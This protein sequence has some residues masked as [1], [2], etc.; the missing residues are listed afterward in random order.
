M[1]TVKRKLPA[2]IFAEEY[3]GKVPLGSLLRF[4]GFWAL[5]VGGSEE[6]DGFLML[7]GEYAGRIFK[8]KP[9]L[10]RVLHIAAAFGWFAAL[11]TDAMPTVDG[12]ELVRLTLTANGPVIF[13]DDGQDEWRPNYIAFA[14]TGRVVTVEDR[15]RAMRF[16]HWT[17][18]LCHKAR[19]FESLTTLFEVDCRAK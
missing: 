11:P 14:P 8:I 9:G 7:Q 18:E 4:R 13:G 6:I 15:R 17:V 10:P 5:R 3:P 16:E 19:P 2:E 12:D 1:E